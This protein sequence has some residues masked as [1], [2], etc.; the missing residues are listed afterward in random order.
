MVI[1]NNTYPNVRK[2]AGSL[3]PLEDGQTAIIIGGGPAGSSC[4]ITLKMMGRKLGS[5]INVI[6]YEGRKFDEGCIKRTWVLA[7]PLVQTLVN[8]LL[9]FLSGSKTYHEIVRDAGILRLSLKFLKGITT[10]S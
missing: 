4:A 3:G 9:D 6:I 7:P 2:V 1:S 10:T 5:E 8:V